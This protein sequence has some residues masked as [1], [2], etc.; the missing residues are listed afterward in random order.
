MEALLTDVPG[1]TPI[2]SAVGENQPRAVELL[3]EKG[4][5]FNTPIDGGPGFLNGYFI[6]PLQMAGTM[7]T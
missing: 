7:V 5:N 4:C 2:C 1:I 6:T 3:I